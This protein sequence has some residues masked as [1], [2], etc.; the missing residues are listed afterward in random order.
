MYLDTKILIK[1]KKELETL[2]HIKNIQPGCRNGNWNV[3]KIAM[4]IMKSG[5]EATEGRRQTNQKY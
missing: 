5:R 2:V 1:N 3:K 4:I